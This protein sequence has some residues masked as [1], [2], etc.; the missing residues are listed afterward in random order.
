MQE[1]TKAVNEL[2][3]S[4]VGDCELEGFQNAAERWATFALRNFTGEHLTKALEVSRA[5]AE[6]GAFQHELRK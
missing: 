1:I 5:M 6:Y 4:S 3:D 2:Q